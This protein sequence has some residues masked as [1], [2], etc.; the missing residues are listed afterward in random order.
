[1]YAAHHFT[2]IVKYC[3][4]IERT[5]DVIAMTALLQATMRIYFLF[6]L[7]FVCYSTREDEY[8]KHLG[9]IMKEFDKLS[10]T[11]P[12]KI[13][14]RMNYIE[15]MTLDITEK[16]VAAQIKYGDELNEYTQAKQLIG[17]LF[18]E[19]NAFNELANV[20]QADANVILWT[21]P[22][23][24]EAAEHLVD[25]SRPKAEWN[26]ITASG[27][28]DSKPIRQRIQAWNGQGTPVHSIQLPPNSRMYKVEN[29]DWSKNHI[30]WSDTRIPALVIAFKKS[31]EL[32]E[33]NALVKMMVQELLCIWLLFNGAREQIKH[34]VP[35]MQ[36]SSN[37]AFDPFDGKANDGKSSD[38]TIWYN[39]GIDDKFFFLEC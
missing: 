15:G 11:T 23:G 20:Q 26:S 16:L 29:R 14:P 10:L 4:Y 2:Y 22:R 18:V 7:I 30:P 3:T 31:K 27:S 6:N 8:S 37:G 33:H 13:P 28:T 17:N 36:L 38:D 35:I 9:I 19:I 32:L 39:K 21:G 1:M 25:D 34:R 12:G 5:R 24:G